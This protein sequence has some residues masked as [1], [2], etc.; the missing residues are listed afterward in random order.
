LAK[1]IKLLNGKQTKCIES[2]WRPTQ[3]K[4]NFHTYED[5]DYETSE[6]QK[7]EK[8]VEIAKRKP[9]GDKMIVFVHSKRTGKE[10]V[11]ALRKSNIRCAFHNASLSH[12]MR[13]KL[14]QL[15]NNHMSGMDIIVS[16]STLSAGVNIG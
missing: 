7:I 2:D 5:E 8:V 14:E 10:V 11:N 6:A 12:T 1:W 3:I 16:T 15:F 9:Y 13:E 4:I